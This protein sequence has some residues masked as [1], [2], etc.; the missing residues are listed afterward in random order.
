[1]MTAAGEHRE[2]LEGGRLEPEGGL[3]RQSGDH[4]LIVAVVAAVIGGAIGGLA[5]RAWD[6]RPSPVS[7]PQRSAELSDL[8]FSLGAQT[9]G[10]ASSDGGKP[11]LSLSVVVAN[12]GKEPTMVTAIRVSGPGAA[13]VASPAGGPSTDL[14]QA[15]DPGHSVKV[16][17]GIS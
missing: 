10:L 4:G 16:R 5:V 8:R 14:P 1:M 13:F 9:G 17:F 15:V 7:F 11:V 12:D 2:V 3:R 6:Q